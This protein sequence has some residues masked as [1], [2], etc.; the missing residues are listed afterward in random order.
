MNCTIN[1]WEI[2]SSI[3]TLLAAI[4]TF[5]TVLEMN[6]QRKESY[7]PKII[8]PKYSDIIFLDSKDLFPSNSEIYYYIENV[9]LGPCIN[10]R[11]N[12]IFDF[13]KIEK[14]LKTNNMPVIIEKD[15][16]ICD[17]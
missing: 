7:K 2:V 12:Y 5:I 11:V 6:K 9:G 13:S 4:A 1:I 8:V 3:G 14:I 15:K 10:F 17:K 16:F